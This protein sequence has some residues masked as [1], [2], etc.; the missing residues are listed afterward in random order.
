MGI[1]Y[2]G[3]MGSFAEKFFSAAILAFGG[4]NENKKFTAYSSS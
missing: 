4:E 2:Y 1:L 3:S